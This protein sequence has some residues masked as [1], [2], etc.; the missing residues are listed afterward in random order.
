MSVSE[1]KSTDQPGIEPGTFRLL[2]VQSDALPTE[3]SSQMG[4]N[5]DLIIYTWATG[6][7]V[8]LHL[9]RY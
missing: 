1:K 7:L 6:K 9:S 3:L 4:K 2:N 8:L 5:I